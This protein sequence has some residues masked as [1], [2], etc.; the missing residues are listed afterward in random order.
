MPQLVGRT[1]SI[2]A[3]LLL[4]GAGALNAQTGAIRGTV[5]SAGSGEPVGEPVISLIE[6]R[7]R[8]T[9]DSAGAFVFRDVPAGRWSLEVRRI[10]YRPDSATVTV[11]AGRET[12]LEIRLI[13][14]PVVLAEV[15][16]TARDPHRER[17]DSVAQVS[18]LSLDARDIRSV[19]ALAEPDLLRVVQLLPGVVT[20]NDYSVGLNV[21]GG[22]A[23]QNLL[24]LD[25]QVVFNPF[26]LGGLVSTFDEQ[27]VRG[28]EFI[29]GGFPARYGGRLSSVLDVQ[30]REGSMDGVRG[31]ASLSL[32]SSKLHLEGPLPLRMGS[33]LVAGRRTYA[34]QVVRAFSSSEFPYHFQ[35]A[36]ARLTLPAVLGGVLAF[37]AF[38]SGDYFDLTL[39]P[40][41]TGQPRQTFRF[42]WGNRVVGLTYHRAVGRRGHLTQRAGASSFFADIAVGPGLFAFTNRVR[43]LA[44]A[45]DLEVRGGRHDLAVGYVAERNDI[46]YR[47]GS[48]DLGIDVARFRYRPDAVEAYVDDQWRPLGWLVV[49]PGLRA[50]RVPGADFT[51]LAP[52][53]VVKAFAGPNT[54]VSAAAG[55]YY[56]YVHSLRNEEIPISLFEFW[57]GANSWVP[58]SEADQAVLGVERWFRDDLSLTVEGFWKGMRNLVDMNPGHDPA[59]VGDEFRTARGAAYGLDLSLRK[60]T[61]RV[62]G[63]AAYTLAK[64]TRIADDGDRFAPAQDRR[65]TLNVVGAFAGPLGAQW[66]VRMGY[67]SPL[68]YTGIAGQWVHR[69]YDPGRNQFLGNSVEP[70]RM[71]RN[72]QRYPAYSRLDVS[73]R[74]AFRW[75]GAR[76]YPTVSLLNAYART[77]VFVYFFDY[78]QNPPLRRG[79]SQFPLLPTVGLEVEF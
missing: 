24:L 11:D 59:K 15:G 30:G 25:G 78:Q 18:T 33:W 9:G 75:L 43:R 21:R 52:R 49:R 46:T 48:G 23:D 2:A 12:M 26:H 34:D 42:D 55:R 57:I 72:A 35:D 6:L 13:E 40:A 16:A 77:N 53:L 10:G 79:L 39:T 27:A 4:V 50:T 8:T 38:G 66:T 44:L 70:Y 36:M 3:V 32:L 14:T 63:W 74:W 45:G 62:T 29:A 47:A 17:F 67:G 68:P 5:R 64:V 31:T 54:A 76:W 19:P 60:T 58:V 7:R 51:G 41:T 37:S 1:G 22:D 65:H 56:Q 61:G 71:A 20:R 69:Y 28:I 73:A